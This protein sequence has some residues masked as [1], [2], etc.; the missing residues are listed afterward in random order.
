[1]RCAWGWPALPSRPPPP[2][3]R[4]LGRLRR[5]RDRHHA[6]LFEQRQ[7][8]EVKMARHDQASLDPPW[9]AS[10]ISGSFRLSTSGILPP[11][12]PAGCRAADAG[13]VRLPTPLGAVGLRLFLVSVPLPETTSVLG[14]GAL[15]LTV[16]RFGRKLL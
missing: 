10:P 13:R 2:V 9:V 11:R 3:R 8:I 7:P 6:E 5:D 4:L 12:R 15:V 1:M 16:E 14:F